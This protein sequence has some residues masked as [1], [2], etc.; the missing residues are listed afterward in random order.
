[1]LSMI[2]LPHSTSVD[3]GLEKPRIRTIIADDSARV[4]AAVCEYLLED[5]RFDVVGF[6][7][8]GIEAVESVCTLKPELVIMDVNMPE[9]N[10]LDATRLIKATS[11]PPVVVIF[12]LEDSRP[13]KDAA[14]KVGADGFC[15]KLDAL[16]SLLP[17][18]LGSFREEDFAEVN[19]A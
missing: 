11:E 17:T 9:M 7:R 13:Y 5:K 1:M 18:V 10:G 12:S 4:S 15:S 19:S 2:D 16:E 6:A 14:E 3:F 8:N